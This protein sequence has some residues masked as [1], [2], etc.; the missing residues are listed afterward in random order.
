MFLFI[1]CLFYYYS[2]FVL[3]VYDCEVTEFWR[4]ICSAIHIPYVALKVQDKFLIKR[5]RV[6]WYLFIISFLTEIKR[7][8]IHY[9]SVRQKKWLY[10]FGYHAS[11]EANIGFE[12]SVIKICNLNF[13]TDSVA[14]FLSVVAFGDDTHLLWVAFNELL[15]C[16]FIS[17]PALYDSG[18]TTMGLSLISCCICFCSLPATKIF[19]FSY[20]K[21]LVFVSQTVQW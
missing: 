3:G 16:V 15:N 5:T 4:F 19:V 9:Y 6:R 18:V 13:Y 10:L 21:L 20:I 12:F 17:I 2:A 14:Y 7:I 8:N 1:L 11:I